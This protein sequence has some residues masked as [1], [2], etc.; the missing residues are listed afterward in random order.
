MGTTWHYE[1][2]GRAVGPLAWDELKALAAVGRVRA[3]DPVW[4]DG[5]PRRRAS[6]VP[7]LLPS[8]RDALPAAPSTGGSSAGRWR[9][10]VSVAGGGA[11][12]VAAGVAK[13]VT[14]PPAPA[15]PPARP[16]PAVPP[17]DKEKFKAF[18]AGQGAERARPHIDRGRDLRGRGEHDAA[19]AAF[20][21]AVRAYPGSAEAYLERG[22]TR[23]QA[24]DPKGAVDDYTEAIRLK[25]GWALAYA[26]RAGSLAALGENDRAVADATEA[27]RLDPAEP[28]AYVNRAMAYLGLGRD[29]DAIRDCDEALRLAPDTAAAHYNRGLARHNRADHPGAISDFDAAIR[30]DPGYG[31]AH[32]NRGLTRLVLKHYAAA[33]DDFAAARRLTPDHAMAHVMEAFV[34]ACCPD[35]A[36]RDEPRAVELAAR[37]CELT[38]GKEF[39]PLAA[40]AAAHAE[41]GRFDEAVRLALRAEA[42]AADG[43]KADVRK[44]LALY[45]AG[46]PARDD[47]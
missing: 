8:E 46:K 18:L 43:Q 32:Y 31:K 42:V 9:S 36:L 38:G 37:A 4:A 20:S 13:Q 39:Y 33:R 14:A 29:E 41:C 34:L 28:V 5:G 35:A 21:D 19:V 12:L 15:D 1:T 3:D 10:W 24:G 2:G 23:R 45:R 25:P 6:D 44:D 47:R 16:A 27:V 22:L 40:L 11:L 26:N 30:L 7:G 17:L